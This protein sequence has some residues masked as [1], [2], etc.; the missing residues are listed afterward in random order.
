VP[1]PAVGESMWTSWMAHLC[2]SGFELRDVPQKS[3][4]I[5]A[6]YSLLIISVSTVGVAGGGGLA[7]G[8]Q[9]RAR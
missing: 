9:R 6:N 8:P 4:W 3:A 5:A 1:E 2:G 7:C